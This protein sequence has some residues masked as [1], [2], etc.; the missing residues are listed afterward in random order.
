[1]KT[2]G[3]TRAQKGAIKERF[4]EEMM[5][6]QS[7]KGQV[8]LTVGQAQLPEKRN[9]KE[10]NMTEAIARGEKVEG[11]STEIDR[12]SMRTK[13]CTLKATGSH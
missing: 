7:L 3:I 5:L 11:C 13:L 12:D 4:P 6:D 2:A 1:M 9:Q 8:G 10:L